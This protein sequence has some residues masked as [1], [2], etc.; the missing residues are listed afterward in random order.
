MRFT[1]S[2]ILIFAFFSTNSFGQSFGTSNLSGETLDAPT[3]LQFGPDGRLY[4]S[5]VE[6]LIYAYTITRNG[7][8]NYQIID[9]EVIDLIND[10]QNHND[11]GNLNNGVNERQVTGL[12]VTGTSANPILYVSSSDSRIGGGGGGSDVN[13]DTNSGIISRLTRTGNSW[14]KVDLV[15]GL[16][17]SEENHATNGMQLDLATNT[18]Y[19]ASGGHTNAGAPSNNFA[20]TTEYALSAAVLSVDLNVINSLPVQ[21]DNGTQ[22]VYDIPTLDDP[23]RPNVGGQDV[24]DPFGGNDGLNQAKIVPGGPVQVYAPGFRNI[25]DVLLTEAGNLYT[26]D[27]GANGGWGG[28]PANEG[29]GTAT[30]NWISGEPGSNGPGPNDPKVNNLDGLHFINGSNYYGGHPNPIR[31]NPNGAGLFTQSGGGG[32]SSG[33]KHYLPC[34]LRQME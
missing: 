9:T 12:L 29:F 11:N 18:L 14:N 25:Y 22:Y 4:V 21:N 1:I 26:W 33:A 8:N 28:H 2:I 10:I 19:V 32:G 3:S 13:L 20:F 27:N 24:N 34:P 16:P 30:N 5:E 6:G 7:A 15:R 31:A 17:R 23:T